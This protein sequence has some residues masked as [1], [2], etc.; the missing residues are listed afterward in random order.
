MLTENFA[1]Q[2]DDPEQNTIQM[3]PKLQIIE[4]SNRGCSTGYLSK[5][6]AKFTAID[7]FQSDR[8]YQIVFPW[9]LQIFCD[10]FFI[11]HIR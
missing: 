11:E 4:T 8:L 3:D 10:S 9:I 5:I 6:F 7:S 2:L 1:Y